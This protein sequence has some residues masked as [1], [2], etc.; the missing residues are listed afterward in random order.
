MAGVGYYR[1]VM[2]VQNPTRTVD[3]F[4]Q[5]TEAWVTIGQVRANLER[6]DTV[7]IMD[8]GGPSVRTDWTIAATWLDG[9]T[10]RSRLR[11]DDHG[12][13]RIFNIRG[14][15]SMHRRRRLQIEASEVVP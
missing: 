11:Y 13:V 5:A 10:S 2:D 9:V 7:E 15:W 4:G 8:D 1:L 3:A 12:T 14:A 6:M